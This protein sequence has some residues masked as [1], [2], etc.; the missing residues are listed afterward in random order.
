TEPLWSWQEVEGAYTY[1]VYVYKASG[2]LVGTGY[3]NPTD[4]VNGVCSKNIIQNV[5]LVHD[6]SYEWFVRAT[7]NTQGSGKIYNVQSF[8]SEFSVEPAPANQP[9]HADLSLIMDTYDYRSSGWFGVRL[10]VV[11][12]ASSTLTAENV[13]VNF[14]IPSAATTSQ[15]PYTSG[16]TQ[17]PAG[18]IAPGGESAGTWWFRVP[19]GTPVTAEAEIISSSAFDIDSTP[20]NQVVSEDDHELR[21]V[22]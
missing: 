21:T 12:T 18:T 10:K 22:Q 11:N 15:G 4:C 13:V 19:A 6:E 16:T 5:N 3:A 14:P 20:N 2:G 1:T 17:W 7:I 8:R 9:D